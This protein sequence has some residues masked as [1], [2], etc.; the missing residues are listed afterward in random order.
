MLELVVDVE[1]RH[2]Q[3]MAAIG[4]ERGGYARPSGSRIKRRMLC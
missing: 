2:L 3:T 4:E 1:L